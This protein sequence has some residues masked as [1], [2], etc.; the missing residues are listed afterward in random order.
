MAGVFEIADGFIDTI[1]EHHPFYAT[2]M[3]V[4]GHDHR[5]DDY[6][7]ENAE[8]YATDV[9]AGLREMKAAVPANDRER[10]CRD[11]FIDEAE[12]TLE[13]FESREH[14]RNMNVLHSPVQ[15]V[16]SIFDLMPRNSVEAWENIASRMENIGEALSTYRTTLDVGR[17]EG[18]VASERQTN[19][20]AEQ[21]EVWAGSGDN[22]PF[23]DSMVNAF[24]ATDITD[25]ALG[26][27]LEKAAASANS[28][29]G[30][31]AEYLRRSYLPDSTPV[32][33]VG[34][35]RYELAARGYLGM[36][37]DPLETY[38]WGW[39]QLAW[40]QSEMAKTAETIK[41]GASLGEVIE[42][43]ETDPAKMI[44][45]EDE[46]AQWMQDLQ[47]RTID[48]MDGTHFDILEPVRTIETLIA[49]PGG[50]LAMYYTGPSEDFSRPG[51]TW[52]PTGGKTEFPVWREVSIA[53]HEGVPG[54]HFQIATH[55]AM[56]DQLSRYQ[57]LVAGTSG[58]AE[59][60][61]L[62]AERLMGELGY[63]ENPDYYMGMLD[64]QALRSVR[65]IIDIGMHLGLKIPSH[66]DFHPGEVWNGD[67]GFE[68][69]RDRVHIPADFA[70]S[71]IDRYLG[72]P[73][74]AICYKVGERVWLETREEA[75]QAAGADFN[76]KEWHNKALS[77]GPMGL[78]QMKRELTRL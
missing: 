54:H 47:D 52:Y 44:K 55:V 64:A 66:S 60:W 73:G 45:G 21:C 65:I 12:L 9:R 40:V 57:R 27:R 61:A 32:D 58:I 11:T 67:L 13:Q 10:M 34:K 70:T 4:P 8:A 50:A 72:L 33:G 63:L 31:M 19:G 39:E 69:M 48:E 46:F 59:G 38:E 71:E 74:Q 25:S 78:A 43:L 17:S 53:Y 2:Y 6:S 3:G 62:Y 28:E 36:E 51:R 5:S 41:P 42:L 29:Y 77:L 23:F 26:D 7:P 30:E 22:S 75:K 18:F 24:A 37:I 49:P 14:L 1:V 15:L 68:F 76:L 56:T 20:C 16:R 35:E